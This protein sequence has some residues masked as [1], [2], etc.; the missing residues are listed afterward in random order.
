MKRTITAD[1]VRRFFEVCVKQF[2]EAGFYLH[3]VRIHRS[4]TPIH[5]KLRS[6][7]HK[8]KSYTALNQRAQQRAQN[9]FYQLKQLITNAHKSIIYWHRTRSNPHNRGKAKRKYLKRKP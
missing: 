2:D 1:E 9:R 8:M 4:E 6:I 5:P 7:T 3:S